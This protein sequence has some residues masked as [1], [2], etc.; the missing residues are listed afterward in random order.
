MLEPELPR[1]TME[2]FSGMFEVQVRFTTK[3]TGLV[4]I[5]E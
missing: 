2:H 5:Y 3:D 1:G 4:G